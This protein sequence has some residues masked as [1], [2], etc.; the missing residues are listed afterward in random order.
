MPDPLRRRALEAIVARL[1][2][3]QTANGY[4]TNAGSVVYLGGSPGLG[5]DDPDVALAVVILDDEV[6]YVGENIRVNLPIEIQALAKAE[7][8]NPYI[9]SESVLADVKTAVELEDRRLGGLLRDR[10]KRG[11]TRT[12]EREPGSLDVGVS[13]LYT[14]PMVEKWGDP[15][16]G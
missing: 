10:M 2:D 7:L 5:K 13:V 4:L 1:Q 15:T 8:D 12:L 14:L 16:D 11:S 9:A 6:T 3:I